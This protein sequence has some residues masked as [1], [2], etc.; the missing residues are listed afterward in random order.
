[1]DLT[2]QLLKEL[3]EAHGI[4]GYASPVREIVERHLNQF[5]TLYQDKI[6]NVFYQID[7]T[8][9]ISRVMVG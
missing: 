1:M 2:P 9:K 3:T 4:P 5:G 6:G 7:D 8:L